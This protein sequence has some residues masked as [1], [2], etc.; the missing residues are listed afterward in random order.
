MSSVISSVDNLVIDLDANVWRLRFSHED[1]ALVTALPE[2]LRYSQ[3]FSLTH[4][5]SPTNFLP[6]EGILQVVLG[7]QESDETWHLGLLL[8]PEYAQSRNSRWCELA[9]WPDPEANVFDELAYECGQSLAKIL[10]VSFNFIPAQQTTVPHIPQRDLPALP[11]ELGFWTLHST[12]TTQ[13]VDIPTGEY[14]FV[15]NQHGKRNL[16][17]QIAW[18]FFWAVI[19]FAVSLMTLLSPIG[20]P[21][22]G[23]LLPN[24]HWLPYLGFLI[25]VGLLGMSGYYVLKYFNAANLIRVTSYGISAWNDD[26]QRW[27]I[28]AQDIQS[29]YSS[30]VVK[31][32]VEISVEHGE[33]NLHMGGGKFS[34]VLHQGAPLQIPLQ[35][36]SEGEKAKQALFESGEIVSALERNNYKTNLEAATLYMGELLNVSTW[37]D[38]RAR[39][40]LWR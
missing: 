36:A 2:G 27:S 4:R 11:L 3:G 17:Q 31:I 37:A 14:A 6:R 10:N 30:E 23:T 40:S 28:T 22:A 38:V 32:S 24:P 19:Y 39:K 8:A 16:I 12:N 13:E 33:I 34:Y 20:L 1:Y 9:R 25:S 7:W 29:I 26:K 15:R 18:N 35:Q 21:N 5:L